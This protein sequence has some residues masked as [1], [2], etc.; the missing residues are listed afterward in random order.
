MILMVIGLFRTLVGLSFSFPT[1]PGRPGRGLW[2]LKLSLDS[3]G[4]PHCGGD[5][6]SA[7]GRASA[8]DAAL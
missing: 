1:W 7:G 2:M 8:S 5:S 3:E 4:S 6:V